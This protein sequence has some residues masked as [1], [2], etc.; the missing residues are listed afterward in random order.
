MD[1]KRCS[2]CSVFIV[3]LCLALVGVIF[4]GL[5]FGVNPLYKSMVKKVLQPQSEFAEFLTCFSYSIYIII[6]FYFF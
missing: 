6:L 3:C 4:V 1:K 5:S 2:C